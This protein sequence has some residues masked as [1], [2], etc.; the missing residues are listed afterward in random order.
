MQDL[1]LFRFP[2]F[3]IF[4]IMNK[5]Y[6]KENLEAIVKECGSIRQVLNKL[7]LKEAGGNYENVKTRIKLFGIDTSHF[8]GMLWNKGKKWSKVKDIS[9]KLVEHST[10]SSGLPISTYVL[11]N[12][13]LK[14]GYKEHICENCENTEW[15]GNLIPLELHHQNGN[16]FDNRIENLKLLCPNCHALTNNYRAKNMSAR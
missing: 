3:M 8:H 4:I 5:K 16:K 9:S 2:Y 1:F 12:Q 13:L 7:G 6:T 15:C 11:K 10:Y 14:L